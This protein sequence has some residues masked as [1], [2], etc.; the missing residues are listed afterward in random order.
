MVYLDYSS[1]T[2]VLYEV[3]E[4]YNKATKEF[5][6]NANSL[7]SLGIKSNKLLENAI[8]QISELFGVRQKEIIFTSGATESNNAAI[9]GVALAYEN[10]GNHIIISKLEHPSVYA[11]CEYLETIGFEISKVKNDENGLIDFEDLKNLIRKDTILVSINA[12]N[13]ELGIRQPL[14]TIRQ[15]IKK[16]N[17]N[18]IFHSDVTQG[19]GKA[20]INLHD[21]DLASMSTH[22]IYGPKGIGIL[23][24]NEKIEITPIIHGST[25]NNGLRP[26]T[27]PLPLIVATSK[28]LRIALSDIDKKTAVVR[29]LN[30]QITTELEKLDGILINKTNYSIPHILNITIQDIR[31]ETFIHALESHDVYIGTSTAC[32]S[33]DISASVMAVWGDRKRALST[34]RI[35]LSHITTN[36]EINRFL[37]AFK[38]EYEKLKEL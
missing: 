21:V 22:K 4:S 9:K 7:H 20:P 6:A 23:Y 2:P 3:L 14:K 15:I 5:M 35:S 36:N 16:Q 17:I 34:I 31:P 38:I 27:P 19:I 28:A 12:V 11:I 1:T 30:E 33:G 18:T 8:L 32:V 13:N 29:K 25:K 10:R 24:K 26:G 37:E